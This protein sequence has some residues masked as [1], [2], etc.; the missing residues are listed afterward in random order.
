MTR[1]SNGEVWCPYSDRVLPLSGTSPE[2]IIPLSLGGCDGFTIPVDREFNSRLGS[3]ID[4]KMA[5]DFLVMLR[6]RHHDARGHSGR[7]PVPVLKNAQLEESGRPVQVSFPRNGVEIWDPRDKRIREL[8]TDVRGGFKARLKLDM[9]ARVR[10][11]AKVALGAGYLLYGDFFRYR[12]KHHDLRL[13]M[14]H[15]VSKSMLRD[16]YVTL[17]LYDQFSEVRDEDREK[18]AVIRGICQAVNGSCVIFGHGPSNLVVCVGILRRYAAS[19]NVEADIDGLDLPDEYDWGQ[20][21][22]LQNGQI[23]HGSL[24]RA[25]LLLGARLGIPDLP[26]ASPGS[27]HHH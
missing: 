4:G 12:V 7:V 26:R 21:V 14:E 25:V 23:Q 11:T 16:G 20:V 27:D 1:E 5:G 10:F 24:R 17:R 9:S 13:L 8:G 2:H 18:I 3:Q 6:R 22:F 15:G 19:V